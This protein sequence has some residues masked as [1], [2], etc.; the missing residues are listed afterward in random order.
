MHSY[1]RIA[2][3]TGKWSQRNF[4]NI[5]ENLYEVQ[6][7]GGVNLIYPFSFDQQ[8]IVRLPLL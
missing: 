6:I 4:Q 2:R 3:S 5:R 7:L 8:C 1:E